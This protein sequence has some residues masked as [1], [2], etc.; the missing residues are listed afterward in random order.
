MN[1]NNEASLLLSRIFFYAL[2]LFHLMLLW[3]LGWAFHL[4]AEC[5]RCMLY[6]ST[7]LTVH[8]NPKMLLFSR[9]LCLFRWFFFDLRRTNPFFVKLSDLF[10][11]FNL[12]FFSKSLK[13]QSKSFNPIISNSN[14]ICS[15]IS[16]DF[17]TT[18]KSAMVELFLFS[19]WITNFVRQ[20]FLFICYG[21]R[22]GL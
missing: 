9:F 15:F 3:H 16:R 18:H 2:V 19:S 12:Y 20:F 8:N 14:N 7:S 5:P 17:N 1:P 22:K 10:F 4:I 13:F 11:N 6:L 21:T